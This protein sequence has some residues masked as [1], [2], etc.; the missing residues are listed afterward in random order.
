MLTIE[1]PINNKIMRNSQRRLRSKLTSNFSIR[2][3]YLYVFIFILISKHLQTYEKIH[4][5]RHWI[6]TLIVIET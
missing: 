3:V 4:L 6:I 1:F 5:T 2:R